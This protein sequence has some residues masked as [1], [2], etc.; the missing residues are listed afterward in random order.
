MKKRIPQAI[1]VSKALEVRRFESPLLQ[2]F[3]LQKQQLVNIS[4]GL[5]YYYSL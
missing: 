3:Y 5:Y 1:N 4:T 2:A